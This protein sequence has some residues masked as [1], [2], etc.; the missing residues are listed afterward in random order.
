VALAGTRIEIPAGALQQDTEITIAP[1]DAPL[2]QT[3]TGPALSFGPDGTQFN[4][5]ITIT[6]PT[7]AA[8]A[9]QIFVR[10]AD[11]TT[12]L[13]PASQVTLDEITGRARFNVSHFTDFEAQ[14]VA[15]A[16]DA[17]CP[18]GNLC[19]SGVC[20]DDCLDGC[21]AAANAGRQAAVSC[22]GGECA[23]DAT[24]P[25]GE[26]CWGGWCA[27]VGNG[28]CVADMDC[29]AG[30]VCASGVCEVGCGGPGRQMSGCCMSDADCA[31]GEACVANLCEPAP[32][33]CAADADCPTGEVCEPE[34]PSCGPAMTCVAGCRGDAECSSGVC[35]QPACLTCPC[36]GYCDI[37]PGGCSSNADCAAGQLCAGGSC[38]AVCNVDADCA[39]VE[40]CLNGICTAGP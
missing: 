4:T 31:T 11:T 3:A 21:C 8:G 34:G 7:S 18:A 15:C 1:T 38:A 19:A 30:E 24:C 13:I 12:E 32:T 5:P 35:N 2:S 17:D 25:A 10:N 22:G 6:L 33:G 29:A 26:M 36:P 39:T 23:G 27:A 28:N 37:A 20:E 14:E 9:V 16:A 40:I